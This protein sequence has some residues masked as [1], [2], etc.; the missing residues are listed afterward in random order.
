MYQQTLISAE[1]KTLLKLSQ[2]NEVDITMCGPVEQP[3]SA[4]KQ[5]ANAVIENSHRNLLFEPSKKAWLDET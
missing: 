5:T 4:C 3:T 1:P 2:S